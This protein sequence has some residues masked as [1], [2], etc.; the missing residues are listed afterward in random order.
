MAYFGLDDVEHGCNKNK[1]IQADQYI[2]LNDTTGA[3]RQIGP[4]RGKNRQK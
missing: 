2:P 3:L 1:D 4:Y